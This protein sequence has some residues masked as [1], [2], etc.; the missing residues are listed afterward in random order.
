MF[1]FRLNLIA[2]QSVPVNVAAMVKNCWRDDHR[3]RP[4]FDDIVRILTPLA[5]SR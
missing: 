4:S 3:E 2:I 1:S 5:S